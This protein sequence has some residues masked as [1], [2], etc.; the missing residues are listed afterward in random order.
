MDLDYGRTGPILAG[1]LDYL[2]ISCCVVHGLLIS[3]RAQRRW[4]GVALPYMIEPVLVDGDP[5]MAMR[6]WVVG[7]LAQPH[8]CGRSRLAM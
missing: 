6:L 8:P 5:H 2:T 3:T 4:G 1:R 7:P